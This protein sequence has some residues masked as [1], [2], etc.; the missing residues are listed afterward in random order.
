MEAAPI[1]YSERATQMPV[2]QDKVR[3]EANRYVFCLGDFLEPHDKRLVVGGWAGGVWIGASEDNGAPTMWRTNHVINKAVFTPLEPI[4]IQPKADYRDRDGKQVLQ[5]EVLPGNDI[6]FVADESHREM[7]IVELTKLADK[8]FSYAQEVNRK[9]FPDLKKWLAGETPIPTLLNDYRGIV[10]QVKAVTEEDIVTKSEILESARLFEVY[11]KDQIERNRQ[12][13][14]RSRKTDMGGFTIGWHQ[15]TRLFARQ[16]GITLED[17]NVYT[18]VTSGGEAVDPNKERELKLQEE[19]NEL[20]RRELELLEQRW[21][22][23][24]TVKK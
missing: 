9:F 12:A 14:E 20:K 13:I 22:A 4:A 19:A 2:D 5:R 8:P 18:Q 11:A 17:D 16:I 10:S 15:R 1:R 23:E 21:K 7:G 6:V 24:S 3:L